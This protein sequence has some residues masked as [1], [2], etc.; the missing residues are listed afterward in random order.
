VPKLGWVKMHEHL[1]LC[2]VLKSATISFSGGRWYASILVDAIN[3][4]EPAPDGTLCGIDWGTSTLATV[5]SQRGAVIEKV[6][7]PKPSKRLAKRKQRLARRVSKQKHRAKK[8]GVKSSKRQYKRQLRLSKL[9]KREANIRADATH[10]FTTDVTKRFKTIVIEDLNASGMS[11]NHALAGA[12]LDANPYE[13]RRQLEYKAALRGGRVIVVDRFFPSTKTCADCGHV[14]DELPLSQRSWTCPACGTVHDRDGNAATVLERVGSAGPE[15]TH[16]DS[17]TVVSRPTAST[18][19][20]KR[21][22]KRR[23]RT[24]N[25]N[26]DVCPHSG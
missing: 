2:G 24:V 25:S 12:V 17:Q 19:R 21:I 26:V 13:I 10:K 22:G 5:S 7:N 23:G 11:K 16:G 20:R 6:A 4:R 18:N 15:S 1:R 3:E 9:Y 8:A 14:I